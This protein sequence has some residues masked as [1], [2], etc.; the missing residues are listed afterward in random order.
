MTASELNGR[1]QCLS[2]SLGGTDYAVGILQVKEILQ[3]ESIIRVPSVPPSVRGVINLRG[4]VVPVVDLS[5]KFGQG[6]TPVSKRTCVLVVE[7]TLDGQPA[8]MGVLADGVTE[9]LELGQ[10]DIEPPPAFGARIQVP[11]LTG[12]GKVGQ[13]FVLLID[14]DLIL[15]AEEK[16]LAIHPPQ[17]PAA[18]TP[19]SQA[20]ATPSASSG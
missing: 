7:A 12:M 13:G 19:R 10:D 17:I 5:L 15:A 14:L 9:V 18:S 1:R 6:E 4:S 3:F 2:F 20:A 11:F 8:V 16:E